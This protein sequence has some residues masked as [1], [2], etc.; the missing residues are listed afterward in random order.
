MVN[1]RNMLI[2]TNQIETYLLKYVFLE[3]KDV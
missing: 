2:Y 1:E 3:V